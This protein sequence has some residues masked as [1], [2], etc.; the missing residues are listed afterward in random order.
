MRRRNQYQLALFEE[1]KDPATDGPYR[2]KTGKKVGKCLEL[3]V[4]N[5]YSWVNYVVGRFRHDN[6]GRNNSFFDRAV[7][8]LE[9][10]EDRQPKMLC[11]HCEQKPVKYFSVLGTDKFGYSV[12]PAY[13]CCGS[14]DCLDKVYSMAAGK[15]PQFYEFK[16]SVLSL[17]RHKAD[18]R[19]IVELFKIVF[20][21]PKR[22]TAQFAFE[23]FQN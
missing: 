17:F 14:K 15:P 20:G 16:F 4:I 10:A 9:K 5:E 7:Q 8:L 3:L 1:P 12:G 23:F 18:R 11:P 6:I 19:Q 22:L 21:L 13:T 2:M